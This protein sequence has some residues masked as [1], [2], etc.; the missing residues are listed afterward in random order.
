SPEPALSIEGGDTSAGAWHHVVA[1]YDG[2]NGCLYVDGSLAAGPTPANDFT[3]SQ[4][5]PL[6]IGIRRDN[7]FPFA[8][9]VDEVALYTNALSPAQ[10]Q[11]HHENGTNRNPSVSYASLI[12][13]E[14]PL[15]YD[16]L[17]GRAYP[18]AA[19][20][21][22]SDPASNSQAGAAGSQM[23]GYGTAFNY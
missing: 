23:R 6:T 14:R 10:I 20:M 7:T 2:T 22:S 18:S 11:G 5:A 15:F 21:N 17:D 3:P 1:V 4:N 13:S 9:T 12:G 8:G 16:R 19:E